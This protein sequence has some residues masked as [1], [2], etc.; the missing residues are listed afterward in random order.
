MR[1]RKALVPDAQQI[2]DLVQQ[3]SGDGTLL[4]RRY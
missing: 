3:Y 2:C 4:P 1:T